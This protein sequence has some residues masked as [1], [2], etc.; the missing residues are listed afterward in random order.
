MIMTEDAKLKRVINK[1]IKDIIFSLYQRPCLEYP[2]RLSDVI[3]TDDIVDS[4]K[5][6]SDC[7]IT[8][9]SDMVEIIKGVLKSQKIK[10]VKE[11]S[12]N[13]KTSIGFYIEKNNNKSEPVKDI[14][15]DIKKRRI[16]LNAVKFF[17]NLNNDP[18][19]YDAIINE[20][21]YETIMEKYKLKSVQS[22]KSKVFRFKDKLRKYVKVLYVDSNFCNQ[23]LTDSNEPKSN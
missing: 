17:V 4:V 11:C 23:N 3:P 6:I 20:L 19:I 5:R 13:K 7:G 9:R 8:E 15:Q 14:K 1:K 22:I 12:G 16:I 18:I 10:E 2:R 21:P